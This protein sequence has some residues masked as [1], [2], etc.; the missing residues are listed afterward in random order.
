MLNNKQLIN[1]NI[2]IIICC[3]K[4]CDLPK[5]DIFLPIQVGAALSENHWGIQRD[6]QLNNV[7]CDNISNKNKSFCELT[8]VYW[9]WKNI[10]KLYPDIK[11]IG[12]NHYR[13]YFN[14]NN[15]NYMLDKKIFP[16]NKINT[17]SINE[18]KIYK[19]LSSNKI[20]LAKKKIYPFSLHIDYSNN[21]I[22]EDYLRMTEIV[23]NNYPDYIQDYIKIMEENNLLSHYNMCIMKYEDFDNYC[24][25]LFSILFELENKIDISKYNDVQ[26]RIFGYM[27]ER[28]F[29]VWI[30]HN[31][32]DYKELPILFYS[33]MNSK[34]KKYLLFERIRFNIAYYLQ[35]PTFKLK[36]IKFLLNKSIGRKVYFLIKK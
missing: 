7:K 16:E 19:Y 26:K 15:P 6:D 25:W 1:N 9:A 24:N 8:A 23:K 30:F 21:H 3:H 27:G 34:S 4:Q 32:K 17:Y 29:N 5:S 36:L 14:F 22:S 31:R 18:K 2:K 11:Y 20:I 10:K 12:I 13:R 28:L 35:L 33:N